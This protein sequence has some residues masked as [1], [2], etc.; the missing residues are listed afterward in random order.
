MTNVEKSASNVGRDLLFVILWVGGWGLL[1]LVLDTQLPTR[2]DSIPTQNIR[3]RAIVY[4]LLIVV[5][6]VAFIFVGRAYED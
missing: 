3:A 6:F 4:M 5:S 2:I 1:D